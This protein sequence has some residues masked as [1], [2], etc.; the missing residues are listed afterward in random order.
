[1]CSHLPWLLFSL[2]KKFNIRVMYDF[3]EVIHLV[4][5]NFGKS[6]LKFFVQL[7][8]GDFG[9]NALKKRTSFFCGKRKRSYPSMNKLGFIKCLLPHRFSEIQFFLSKW[10]YNFQLPLL[11][12]LPRQSNVE[13]FTVLSNVSNQ[14]PCIGCE[15]F[16]GKIK[17]NQNSK[18]KLLPLSFSNVFCRLSTLNCKPK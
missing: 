2:T 10:K 9:Q 1:M 5:V 11:S 7:S 15:K 16:S 18:L 3:V 8:E 12:T 13:G 14:T 4:Q 17:E 6:T